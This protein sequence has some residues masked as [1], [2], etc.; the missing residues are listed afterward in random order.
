[1][2]WLEIIKEVRVAMKDPDRLGDI[3]VLKSELSRARGNADTE[4]K[5]DP[6]RGY[7]P[8]LDIDA[9]SALPDGTFG[10]EYVRFLKA[11]QIDPLY[12]TDNLP[13]DMIA[14]NA[15]NVRYGAIHDM[16]HV[17][18]GFD[19]SW[20]GEVGVWAFVGAQNYGAAFNFASWMS[21]LIA[22]F[23][24]PFRLGACWRAFW[25]G[26]AMGARADTLIAVR[27]EEMM[28]LPLDDVRKQLNVVG[29]TAGYLPHR[30]QAAPA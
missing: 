24:A 20:V 3:P 12:I 10:R 16:V 14:R 25:R 29:G 1:M 19:T 13:A 4:A 17:L 27:L 9:L 30:P 11:N 23:R 8:R 26:R 15:L 7:H 21:L 18:L 6:V 22:P 5:L 2:T 28:A